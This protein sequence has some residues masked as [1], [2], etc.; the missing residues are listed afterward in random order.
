MPELTLEEYEQT[1]R[2]LGFRD[3]KR[4]LVVHALLALASVVIHWIAF[5]RWGHRTVERK[6][7]TIERTAA[8]LRAA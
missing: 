5:K 8:A 2:E 4:G 7:A 1:E 3:A 6:Q